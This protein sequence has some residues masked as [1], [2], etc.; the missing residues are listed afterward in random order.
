M[1]RKPIGGTIGAIP[2]TL[3][4]NSG[5]IPLGLFTPIGGGG[6]GNLCRMGPKTGLMGSGGILGGKP[7]GGSLPPNLGGGGGRIPAGG[8]LG[9][10]RGPRFNGLIFTLPGRPC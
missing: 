6:S 5:N 2:L 1:P 9:P 7:G 8:S 3:G 10:S 4:S